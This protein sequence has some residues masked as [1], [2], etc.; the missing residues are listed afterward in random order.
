MSTHISHSQ[1]LSK[2]QLRPYEL[3][4]QV[5]SFILTHLQPADPIMALFSPTIIK[6]VSPLDHPFSLQFSQPTTVFPGQLP[7][8]QMYCLKKFCPLILDSHSSSVTSQILPYNGCSQVS[9]GSFL[10][11]SSSL[12]LSSVEGRLSFSQTLLIFCPVFQV[13]ARGCW[14]SLFIQSPFLMVVID[15]P[16]LS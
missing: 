7:K 6:D 10:K 15:C 16:V 13:C 11:K 8:F 4:V 3:R 1:C 2:M 14:L 5:S 12:Q 9:T